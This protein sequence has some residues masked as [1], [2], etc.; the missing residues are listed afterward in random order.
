MIRNRRKSVTAA[1]TLTLAII[2]GIMI[3]GPAS[4]AASAPPEEPAASTATL[5]TSPGPLLSTTDPVPP[6]VAIS[7]IDWSKVLEN[8]NSAVECE[9]YKA[10]WMAD[11][12]PGVAV[13]IKYG[14]SW[15]LMWVKA[16][17]HW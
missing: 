15:A 14:N 5:P 2:A 8:Y 10:M 9:F 3:G 1:A 11:N 6:T 17:W 12:I 4:A 7:S 13:C 16:G